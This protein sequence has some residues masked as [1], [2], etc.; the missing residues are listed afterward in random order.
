MSP[1]LSV[2]SIAIIKSIVVVCIRLKWK[3]LLVSFT[4]AILITTVNIYSNGPPDVSVCLVT[5]RGNET[6]N[7]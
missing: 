5:D 4:T 6:G 7:K 1:I 3:G 2:T